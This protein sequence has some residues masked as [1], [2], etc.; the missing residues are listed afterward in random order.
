MKKTLE[1]LAREERNAYV[2]QWR[3]ANRD[4][5]RA[6]NKRYWE[7]KVQKKLQQEGIET[8]NE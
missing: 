2:R 1:E 8:E 7:K 4:K 6:T 3:A 5:V